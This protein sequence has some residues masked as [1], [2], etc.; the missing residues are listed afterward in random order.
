M[1]EVPSFPCSHLQV[2]VEKIAVQLAN[3]SASVS[4]SDMERLCRAL[5]LEEPHQGQDDC[6]GAFRAGMYI[7]GGIVGLH[8]SCRT[9]PWSNKAIA[10]YVLEQAANVG[11]SSHFTSAV[12]LVN[13]KTDPHKDQA[14]MG[15]ENIIIPV[16]CFENGGLWVERAGGA[17]FRVVGNKR[18]PGVVL[19]FK[20]K[21]LTVDAKNN[22]HATV[23]WV[24]DRIVIS[25][26]TLRN[27]SSLRPQ[28]ASVLKDLGFLGN[29]ITTSASTSSA[30]VQDASD[31]KGLGFLGSGITTSA[32]TSSAPVQDASALKGL[33]SPG[34][35]LTSG[36]PKSLA[37]EVRTITTGIPWSP[38]EFVAKACSS[39]H[40]G[41]IVSGIPSA[42]QE[43]IRKNASDSP[44]SH[45]QFRTAALRPWASRA[46]ELH[47]E[48]TD[49]KSGLPPHCQQVL[50]RKKLCLFKELLSE[51]GHGDTTLVDEA[52]QGFR[53][54]GAIPDSHIFKAKR[55]TA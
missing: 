33:G 12:V 47:Q 38:E 20:G 21:P 19:N 49:Y 32:S 17:N 2:D 44:A 54:S 15:E 41:N 5:P 48:E 18:V 29:G 51:C 37:P 43:V 26:Y 6:D 9:H 50:L 30:P 4:R 53:L 22:Y 14:N 25:A 16:T 52:S 40:P 34:N 36:A 35:G 42:L 24:G 27:A 28:D 8:K 3:Q 45:G 31:L 13:T 7:K 55:T 10:R 1:P 23:P 46:R 39:A 11:F